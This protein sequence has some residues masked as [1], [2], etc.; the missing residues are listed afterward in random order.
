MFELLAG[1]IH[2][3]GGKGRSVVKPGNGKKT[4]LK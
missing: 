3:S 4:F 1:R 2:G